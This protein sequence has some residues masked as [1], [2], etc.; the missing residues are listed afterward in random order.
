MCWCQSLA[1]PKVCNV[2]QNM[3]LRQFNDIRHSLASPLD[4]S[5]NCN[6]KM[7]EYRYL[8]LKRT[9]LFHLD[10]CMESNK[11]IFFIFRWKF[12]WRLRWKI[13]D[14]RQWKFI[15]SRLP[16]CQEKVLSRLLRD[17]SEDFDGVTCCLVLDKGKNQIFEWLWYDIRYI[18]MVLV[19]GCHRVLIGIDALYVGSDQHWSINSNPEALS[20]KWVE[21]AFWRLTIV[22]ADAVENSNV[23]PI[24]SATNH[25]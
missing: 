11:R 22:W 4:L 25:L 10:R 5:M 21:I 12:L 9:W 7:Y 6:M 17:R 19:L 13:A 16:A 20:F 23:F 1:S 3:Q 15:I 18:H 24:P 8:L 14:R 2:R